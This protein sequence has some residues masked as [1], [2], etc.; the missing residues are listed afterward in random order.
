MSGKLLAD[1]PRPDLKILI[2][3]DRPENLLSMSHLLRRPD[4]EILTAG[5]GEEALNLMLDHELALVLLDVQMPE[6]DGFEVAELMHGNERTRHI[7]IIFVTAINK[8]R[9]HIFH[10]YET[11]AVDYLFKPVDPFIIRSKVD[12]FL[13]LKRMELIR[14]SLLDELNHANRRLRDLSENKSE[15]LSAAS[16][17]LRTPLTVIKE[18]CALVRDEVVGSTTADQQH[19]MEAALRNCNRL[20]QLVN[21]LLDLDSIESGYG[22]L[23]RHEVQVGNILAA[24]AS[25]FRVQCEREGLHLYTEIPESI[26]PVL[27]DPGLITQV[28]V[29]LMGNAIKFS[30]GGTCIALGAFAHRGGVLIRVQDEGPGIAAEDQKRVFEKF[31]Q[32]NRTPGPGAQGTGLGLAISSKIADLLDGRLDLQSELGV[33][34]T[35][36]FFLPRYSPEAHLGAFVRDATRNLLGVR[37]EW[38]LLL[39]TLEGQDEVPDWLRREMERTI[40]YGHDR[41]QVVEAGGRPHLGVLLKTDASGA[42]SFL[43]RLEEKVSRREDY[44]LLRYAQVPLAEKDQV[45]FR[46]A[47]EEL[48]YMNLSLGAVPAGEHREQGKNSGR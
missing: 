24:C 39:F 11:G 43:T 23:M 8:E 41:L 46:I 4:L 21:D 36:S 29:N 7:P 14:E 33:G 16:H 40:R 35:F 19:C 30:S 2:V 48:V 47:D 13:E 31:T 17:E 22:N 15:F 27:G 45:A 12:V 44:P 9:Q 26:P 10:G 25:D 38:T 1:G 18:N 5:S 28:V 20:T 3:D 32:V 37:Q 34:S 42:A 6:M